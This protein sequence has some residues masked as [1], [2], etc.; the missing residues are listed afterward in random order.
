MINMFTLLSFI[1]KKEKVIARYQYKQEKEKK[2][3]CTHALFV[4]QERIEVILSGKKK[5][6]CSVTIIPS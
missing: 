5:L 2:G 6:F 4:Q 3:A 1:W